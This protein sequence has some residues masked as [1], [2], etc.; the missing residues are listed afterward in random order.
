[1]S[2]DI[3]GQTGDR[4]HPQICARSLRRCLRQRSPDVGVVE[5]EE[6]SLGQHT[7]DRVRLSA[8]Q[9]LATD[10][11]RVAIQLSAPER[12]AHD[13]DRPSNIVRNEAATHDWRRPEQCEQ[14]GSDVRGAQTLGRTK[15]CERQVRGVERL[16]RG[17]RSGAVAPGF[18]GCI[19]DRARCLR[20]C[21][22]A[23]CFSG[24][25]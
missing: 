18:E 1:L 15:A 9:N 25:D 14:S 23:R 19:A 8:E 20:H 7:D 16:D 6:E 13:H 10:C 5:C 21:R 11:T 12:G 4:A 2:R 3:R 17:E 24:G 22:V